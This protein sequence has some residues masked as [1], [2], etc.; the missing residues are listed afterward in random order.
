MT[1]LSTRVL[2]LLLFSLLAAGGAEASCGS[3]SCP[4]DLHALQGVEMGKFSLDLSLQYIDQDQP[5]IGSRRASV[6]ELPSDH[7][8]VRT[9][10]RLTSL[11]L[12]YN[13]STRLQLSASLAYVSR[14]HDHIES[15]TREPESWNFHDPGDAVIQ[16]RYR[17]FIAD[18]AA[19]SSLWITAGAKLPT[20]T[21]HESGSSG[22]DAEV[23]ITPGSGST[24]AIVGLTWQ[25]GLLRETALAG[26]MG[27]TTLVPFF[28]STTYR[29]NG[30]G[31]HEYRRG[32]EL[33]I[34]AGSEYPISERFHIL[35]QLNARSTSKDDVGETEED[36]DFTG[37][38]YLFASPG[39]RFVAGDGVSLYALVQLPVYQ[40]VNGLQLTSRANYVVG[41]HRSF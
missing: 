36:R 38:R 24:D 13:V 11:Q 5:R 34:S 31:T 17:L 30:R 18:N 1:R 28:V 32:N 16:G 40:H 14:S 10:N 9:I 7:D 22:E 25:S 21:R 41:I 33:Q 6:G 20:G 2:A 37:A 12:G 35:G 29:R 26:P 19:H 4:L 3:S 15:E 23:T 8:E 27:N 39:V